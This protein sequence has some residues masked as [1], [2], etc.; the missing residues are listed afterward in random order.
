MCCLSS[1]V[2][3]NFCKTGK[4]VVFFCQRPL[5]SGIR[6][7][8]LWP[9]AVWLPATLPQ[10]CPSG[11]M[12]GVVL[13]TGIPQLSCVPPPFPVP[14]DPKSRSRGPACDTAG[15]FWAKGF[16]HNV[17]LHCQ[18][19]REARSSRLSKYLSVH[20]AV[21]NI[22]LSTSPCHKLLGQAPKP[23]SPAGTPRK[24]YLYTSLGPMD[25]A[26][27]TGAPWHHPQSP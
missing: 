25:E 27:L 13:P 6:E 20:P 4:V 9:P 1:T 19:T 15:S 16:A 14:A 2:W 21:G 5:L 26:A 11:T 12:A 10:G 22:L 24:E 23:L 7:P 3:H 17:G 8:L 18:V